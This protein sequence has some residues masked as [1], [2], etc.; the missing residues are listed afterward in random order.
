[1]KNTLKL[2]VPLVLG[3]IAGTFNFLALKSSVKEVSFIKA[4][5]DIQIGEPFSAEKVERMTI[6]AQYSEGLN[7]SAIRFQDIGL[8]S[9]QV[10]TRKIFAGDVIFYR[11]TGGL[12]GEIY[13]F[14]QGDEAALPVALDGIPT[15]PK[16]R[17][18]DLVE[19]KVPGKAGETDSES[20]WIGPFRL[21]SVGTSISNQ[22]EVSE[23][24][25][26]SVAYDPKNRIAL[27][28]LEDFIDRSQT[29]GAR[30][31]GIKLKVPTAG[32]GK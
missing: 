13:D 24:K 21:V 9:G 14:R 22:T 1:M 17:V 32:D 5:A 11:D 27:D 16:M 15:P 3:L 25:R 18:G 12:T 23:S 2:I 30:L 6:L 29:E 10:A 4:K 19:L 20:K 7:D 31:I 8:L 28:E 26:I